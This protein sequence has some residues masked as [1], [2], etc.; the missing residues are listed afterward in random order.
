MDR[1]KAIII[2]FGVLLI[3]IIV[4]AGMFWLPERRHRKERKY[5][6]LMATKI[7][8]HIKCDYL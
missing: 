1:L 6:I 2:G 3:V 7:L 8:R 5:L 4:I